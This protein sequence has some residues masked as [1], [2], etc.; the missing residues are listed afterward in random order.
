MPGKQ[1]QS[2]GLF[3]GVDP[4]LIV[5]AFVVAIGFSIVQ[6]LTR[7]KEEVPKSKKTARKKFPVG[8]ANKKLADH[9]G[10]VS[11]L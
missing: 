7:K 9:T 2:A 11:V 3:G 8:N 4:A 10:Q 1:G 6:W 5:I